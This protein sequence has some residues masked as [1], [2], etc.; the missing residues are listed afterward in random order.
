[1]RVL[2]TV[3]TVAAVAT[4]WAQPLPDPVALAL[5]AERALGDPDALTE[6]RFTFVVESQGEERARRTHVW[7]PREGTLRVQVG[8]EEVLLR[9]VRGR[10]LDRAARD[11]E[12][13]RELWEA[14][15]PGTDAALAARSW[16]AFINDSFWLYAPV[17]LRAPGATL[18]YAEGWLRVVY[19]DVGVTPGDRYELRVGDDGR[20]QEW[21]YRLSAG[22][23]GRWTWSDYREVGPL[24][25]SLRRES[26]DG[27]TV[28]RFE[29]VAAEP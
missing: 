26:T 24:S 10:D 27:N 22:R 3:A 4:A 5:R 7:R 17:R 29:D 13:H 23:E 8:E 16:S 25:V 28:I 21:R 19:G 6:L 20:V 1:M 14:V 11:P 18:S 2:A 12:G 15:S 9:G